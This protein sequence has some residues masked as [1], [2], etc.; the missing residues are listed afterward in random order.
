MRLIAIDSDMSM[1]E[2]IV[3]MNSDDCLKL[4]VGPDDRVRL[5]KDHRPV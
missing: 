4:G 2:P 3:L 5:G 1:S